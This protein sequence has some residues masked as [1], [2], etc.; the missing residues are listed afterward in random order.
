MGRTESGGSGSGASERA[1]RPPVAVIGAGLIGGAW[2]IVFARAGHPVALY[3]LDRRASER[4]LEQIGVSVREMIAGGLIADPVETIVGR[5]RIASA[6]EEAL[7]GA[8]LVQENVRE[9]LQDKTAIFIELDRLAPTEAILASS[10]SWLPASRFTRSLPGRRRCLVAH[11]VNPPSLVPLV[12]I[13]PAPWTDPGVV[14]RAHALYER[15]GQVPV[16]LSREIEGFILNRLQGAVLD[17]AFS[18]YAQGYASAEDIDRV[19]RDGLAARWSFM[20]PFE[21]IDLN[22]PGG[23]IDY[24][25]RYGPTYRRIAAERHPFDWDPEVIRRLE[26]ERRARLPASQLEARAA[27]RDRRLMLFAAYKRGLPEE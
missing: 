24:A 26:R 6:L 21:T 27:W 8:A 17:E 15:A 20:G 5:V 16:T 18:L 9:T 13:A 10:T 2:A 1:D 11:P 4:S 14:A 19:M 25:E 23:V 3:D 22:A 12:E 7:A